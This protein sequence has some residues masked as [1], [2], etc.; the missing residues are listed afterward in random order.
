MSTVTGKTATAMQTIADA[1]IV[2][3]TVNGSGHL[4]LTNSGGGTVDAGSVQ[5]PTGP[6]GLTGLQGASGIMPSG[7]IVMFGTSIPPT[8]WLLCDNTLV[9]CLLYTSPSP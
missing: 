7:T 6:T 3:G 1:S 2:S 8:G 9:S 4:I 5:G